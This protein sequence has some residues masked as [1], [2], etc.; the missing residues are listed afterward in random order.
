MNASTR[1]VQIRSHHKLEVNLKGLRSITDSKVVIDQTDKL[2]N[3]S[4]WREYDMRR[5]ASY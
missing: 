3:L 4:F 1:I 2:I 5:N